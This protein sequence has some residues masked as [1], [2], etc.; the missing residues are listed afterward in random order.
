MAR[1]KKVEILSH[2]GE[3]LHPITDGDCVIFP[4]GETLTHKLSEDEAVMYTPEVVNSSPMF[5]V[6]E[7]DSSDY[8][9]NVLDGAYQEAVLKG[10]TYVNTIQEPSADVITLP[11]PF[12]EYERTQ[13]KTFT[14]MQ[15]GTFG[16]N[17]VGQSYVN[18]IQEP[19]EPSYVALG[20][21]LEF[22]NKKVEYT[23]D[24]Q[25]KSAMLN[26]MTLVNHYAEEN[27]YKS[28]NSHMAR[29]GNEYK[30]Y[31]HPTYI[32]YPSNRIKLN[33]IET[34]KTYTFIFDYKA[35]MEINGYV[36]FTT[37]DGSNS[38]NVRTHTLNMTT[39]YQKAKLLVQAST[40]EHSWF[41]FTNGLSTWSESYDN[42]EVYLKN[43]IVLEGDH[44]QEDIPY[45][46]GMQSVTMS[47]E[48]ENV[49]SRYN[50]SGAKNGKT[51]TIG[52]PS[53]RRLELSTAS[54]ISNYNFK[55]NTKYLM[56]FKITN[57]NLDGISSVKISFSQGQV[58]E[59]DALFG[60]YGKIAVKVTKNGIY[61]TVLTTSNVINTSMFV[62]RGFAEEWENTTSTSRTLTISQIMC[63]EYQNGME[64]WD[65]PYFETT[66][67]MKPLKV[68]SINKNLC[69]TM[70]IGGIYDT[71]GL[72][73]AKTDLLRSDFIKLNSTLAISSN[74]VFNRIF[75]YDKN[76][77][78]VQL[79][80][81]DATGTTNRTIGAT[82]GIEFIRIRAN[83]VDN[84]NIQI[85][86][87]STATDYVPH[88]EKTISALEPITLR[89][90]GNVKD[91]LDLSTG[92]YVQRIGEI[93]LDGSE[94]IVWGVASDDGKLATTICFT[95]YGYIKD[96]IMNSA[97]C[98]HFQ[99]R[100]SR[101][102]IEH[103]YNEN[104][105]SHQ[106]LVFFI[107][108]DKLTTPD[109][110]GF[111]QWLSKNPIKIQYQ[112]ATPITRK[113]SLEYPNLQTYTDI[114]HVQSIAMD[115]TLIPK[116]FLPSDI[117]YKAMLKPNT[118][119]NVIV[120]REVIDS[121]N[122]LTVNLG[123]TTANITAN[124]TVVRTPSTLSNETLTFSGKDNRLAKAML[125]ESGTLINGDLPHFDGI[126]DVKLGRVVENLC[127]A[128]HTT[129]GG[130]ASTDTLYS[131]KITS[132]I[133][134]TGSK[135]HIFQLTKNLLNDKKYFIYCP[136][137]Y[138]YI[139]YG[140][141][142]EYN[143]SLSYTY[144]SCEGVNKKYAIIRIDGNQQKNP[145][146][147]FTVGCHGNIP[148]NTT[149]TI[150]RP[151]I[152][153]YIEGMEN[154][155]W[156]SIGY[157]TGTKNIGNEF[158]RI[159]NKNLFDGQIIQGAWNSDTD[160]VNS[161][162]YVCT[163]NRILVKPN[164]TYTTSLNGI[165]IA[166]TKLYIDEYFN[167]IKMEGNGTSTF[168]TPTNCKYL[169]LD[170]YKSEG[171]IPTDLQNLQLEEASS[172]TPYVAHKY[173]SLHI[174]PNEQIP[175]TFVQGATIFS[176]TTS[177]AEQ[178]N[179]TMASRIRT[180]LLDLEP[181]ETYRISC[182]DK[183]YIQATAF[184][185]NSNIGAYTLGGNSDDCIFTTTKD[186]HKIC[187]NIAKSDLNSNISP[188]VLHQVRL[189]KVTDVTLRSVGD[190][191]DELDLTRGVYIQRMYEVKL[192]GFED[193]SIHNSYSTD[194]HL[195]FYWG[196]KKIPSYDYNKFG[197]WGCVI[198]VTPLLIPRGWNSFY[199]AKADEEGVTFNGDNKQNIT[200]K[201]RKDRLS[202]QDVNGFKQWLQSNPITVQ[203]PLETPIEHKINIPMKNES[204]QTIAKPNGIFTLP[205][206]YSETNHVDI[207][208]Q[209]YPKVQSR[210][211][212]S[213]PVIANNSQLHTVFHNK[214]GTGN[215]TVNL[216][217]TSVTSVDGT[218]KCTVTTPSTISQYELR[219]SGARNKVSNVC[220]FS[221]D[222]MNVNVPYVQGMMNAVNPIVKNIG[223]NLFD[224]DLGEFGAKKIIL[225][226]PLPK[227]SYITYG[228]PSKAYTSN[229]AIRFDNTKT[230][231]ILYGYLGEIFNLTFET[232]EITFYSNGYSFQNS[233]NNLL[234]IDDF[235]LIKQDTVPSQYEPYKENICEPHSEDIITLRS[236]PNGVRDE[237]NLE[238][239]EYIQ[240]VGEVVLDGSA[241][242]NI[243]SVENNYNISLPEVIPNAKLTRDI[244]CIS[245]DKLPI[246]Y[247]EDSWNTKISAISPH[248]NGGRIYIRNT[249]YNP[250]EWLSQNPLTIQYELATP[251]IKQIDIHNY[252]H[253]YQNG[254]VIIE[255][256]DP[257]T[258]VPA[259][260]TYKCVTNRSGQI[261]EHT[262]QVE[263]QER[264]INELET[265]VLENIRMNQNRSQNFL[266]S[267][268]ST[269]E[270]EEE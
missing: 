213:Y 145:Y 237:L 71:T 108:R 234:R 148:V 107:N 98:S 193:W 60:D 5:K 220:V 138:Q 23:T 93:V 162:N 124:R 102:D 246:I 254:H 203:Y 28:Q 172:A 40:S 198:N 44:T 17:L 38:W 74:N 53:T 160:F 48:L 262:E 182:G 194:N 219:L 16:L 99:Q 72:E 132:K 73:F 2:S 207:N 115:G 3:V 52:T 200:I 196:Y 270:I 117:S 229:V 245:C 225:K 249:A 250:K 21:N 267:L 51:F 147:H 100:Y 256:G 116:I 128:N 240:R 10:Q 59:G 68:Q 253:S 14:E 257:T 41:S 247:W 178:S 174:L 35:T 189:E 188:S 31:K 268:I 216:C 55:P 135:V 29:T 24:G 94:G 181:N 118:S 25:I 214:V 66:Q 205:L 32:G 190:I 75:G 175:L 142:H 36:G 269:L 168:T 126:G 139:I 82:S 167:L 202:S 65:L 259:Q 187:I 232:N 224:A 161:K 137:D 151:I 263:K 127:M 264:Q 177:F 120:D 258:P 122:Q 1:N 43:I 121:T 79:L 58:S 84:F 15:D 62:V 226:R 34:G 18:C 150:R 96:A 26:G 248:D 144:Q 179:N 134:Q 67:L 159:G 95:T 215:L 8:S 136:Y 199:G 163:K 260:L 265:L 236:L 266:T 61:R 109:Y 6:G 157:F 106:A 255:S 113:I 105:N 37:D 91:T 155:D 197:Q 173:N 141:R 238:T 231:Q 85:E 228:N 209:I 252:P 186:V 180:G 89:A 184:Y 70:T 119:Y 87:S 165:K 46:Q 9:A 223:K 230:G 212:I 7:G 140:F 131:D 57:L 201:I 206:M 183:N 146:T 103:F 195:C 244:K 125:I 169:K 227:G 261:Q 90:I 241:D 76:K 4:D 20:E 13:S 63:I 153:E 19:S 123:G 56:Q 112:L 111:N 114:T 211:Y 47:T 166:M 158:M 156:E 49:C 80:Y 27:E 251:I 143:N 170:Y 239:G 208:S 33:N 11:T 221:G 133:T 164:T 81:T 69:P 104:L 50:S 129:V 130:A 101:E 149:M 222:Y 39:S 233:V 154:W 12:T 88:Q 243:I 192:N 191:K 171:V 152:C 64:N 110:D 204:N 92:E 210:D 45:F 86:E 78:F 176:T 235:M 218:S 42:L 217:G 77:K 22:Q 97:I 83:Y 30:I 54:N 185:N 242:E